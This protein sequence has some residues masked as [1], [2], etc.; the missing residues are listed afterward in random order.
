MILDDFIVGYWSMELENVIP[1]MR[2]LKSDIKNMHVHNDPAA[3]YQLRRWQN[4]NPKLLI[5]R[6]NWLIKSE[7]MMPKMTS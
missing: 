2:F 3:A 1:S 5:L 7:R 4:M 6:G